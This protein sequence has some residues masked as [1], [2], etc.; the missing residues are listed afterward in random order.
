MLSLADRERGKTTFTDPHHLLLGIM[1][2]SETQAARVV[3][4]RGITVVMARDRLKYLD[5][6]LQPKRAVQGRDGPS[7]AQILDLTALSDDPRELAF[8]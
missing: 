3:L 4:D 7:E 5:K 2:Q 6:R 8:Y 1:G